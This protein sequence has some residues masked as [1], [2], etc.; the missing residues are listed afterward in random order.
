MKKIIAILLTLVLFTAFSTAAFAEPVR[1]PSSSC[2]LSFSGTTAQCTAKVSDFGKE[3]K[4]TMSLW[5]GMTC[6]VMWS[7]SGTSTVS[8]SE[9]CTVEAGRSY[10]LQVGGTVGGQA[11]KTVSVT[12]TCPG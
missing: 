9:T 2:N 3:I 4:L 8:M 12:R 5:D 6:L 11:L 1:A 10:T 7:D